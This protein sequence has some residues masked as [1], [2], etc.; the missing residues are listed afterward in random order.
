M[1]KDCNELKGVSSISSVHAG[2]EYRVFAL[3]SPHYFAITPVDRNYLVYVVNGKIGVEQIY[4]DVSG[5]TD[6]A[7]IIVNDGVLAAG[8]YLYRSTQVK[9][10]FGCTPILEAS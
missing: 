5:G 9:S 4:F 3:Q 2:D 1:P 6:L 8:R 10:A 7:A